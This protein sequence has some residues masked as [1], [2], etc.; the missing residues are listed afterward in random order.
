MRQNT[1]KT[2]VVEAWLNTA[3]SCRKFEVFYFYEYCV[4]AKM[5]LLLKLPLR[6][7][8]GRTVNR[9]SRY[10]LVQKKTMYDSIINESYTV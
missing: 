10:H 7:S 1:C 5:I 2:T 9:N 6:T 8:S 3:L 4:N